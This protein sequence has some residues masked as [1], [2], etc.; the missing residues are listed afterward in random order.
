LSQHNE[1]WVEENIALLMNVAMCFEDSLKEVYADSSI[2]PNQIHQLKEAKELKQDV[3]I[4]EEIKDLYNKVNGDIEIR[5]KLACM[6]FNAFIDEDDYINNKYLTNKIEDIFFETDILDINEHPFKDEILSII[7]KLNKKTYK[8][9]F[10]RLDDKKAKLMLDIVTNERTKDDIFS[11]VTLKEDK[12]K[13]LGQLVQN[14]NFDDILNRAE[15]LAEQDK[16]KRSDF[17]HKY[18]IGT[19][20]ERLI[21]E[22]LSSEL[23]DRV[24]FKNDESV[25]TT[26][27][28][29]GQDI[30][31]F[32]DNNPI[33]FIEVKSRWNSDSSVLMSKLQ[34]QRAVEEN[35]RYS[36]CSVDVS[37]YSGNNDKYNLSVEE[38]LPLTK[39]VNNIGINI[40]PLIESNLFAEKNSLELIHL[41]DYRGIIPQEII[42][43]GSDFNNFINSLLIKINKA[44]S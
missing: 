6:G 8:E 42:K 4:L 9:L 10:P 37:K 15:Q 36:L 35:K 24:S 2:Y 27:I 29:G 19:N 12:L 33:Y 34:L 11:I 16:L 18:K 26:N 43:E 3:D 17:Q 28:Q 1:D 40:E 39:F 23:Q 44:I 7:S 32:L 14:E 41:I 20:I 31:V 22:K 21:R 38:I 13:K 5:S 25:E 30:V